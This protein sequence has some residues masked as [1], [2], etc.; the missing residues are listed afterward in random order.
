MKGMT[1]GD[2]YIF[3]MKH[4]DKPTIREMKTMKKWAFLLTVLSLL[5]ITAACARKGGENDAEPK[6]PPEENAEPAFPDGDSVDEI[7]MID[8]DPEELFSIVWST[9]FSPYLDVPLKEFG[10]PSESKI[11]K[12]LNERF[13]VILDS[14]PANSPDY[15]WQTGD[16]K[17]ELF[18]EGRLPDF[19]NTMFSSQEEVDTLMER[20][21]FRRIPWDMV[22]RYAPRYYAMINLDPDMLE[23]YQTDEFLQYMLPA[24][25][26]NESM[27]EYVSIYRLDWLEELGF[28]PKGDI[29]KIFANDQG[30]PVYFTADAFSMDEF[31]LIQEA[32]AGMH[33]EHPN[34]WGMVLGGFARLDR[35][36]RTPLA[37]MFGVTVNTVHENGSAVAWFASERYRKLLE[38]MFRLI[39]KGGIATGMQ[40]WSDISKGV[41][42]DGGHGWFN[43][44][45]QYVFHPWSSPIIKNK[46]LPST[47]K[48][49]IT[50]P[51]IASSGI[52]G[53]TGQPAAKMREIQDTRYW[54][55]GAHVSD[56]K[57]ARILRIWDA[58]S[59]EPDLYVLTNFGIEGEDFNWAGKPFDSPALKTDKKD[60]Y[61]ELFASEVLDGNAGKYIY[62]FGSEVLYNFAVSERGQSMVLVPYKNEFTG[63]FDDERA[64]V[65]ALYPFEDLRA[66]HDRFYDALIRGTK[67]IHRSWDEYMD[68]LFAAGLAEWHKFFELLPV[69]EGYDYR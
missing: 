1:A 56:A 33:L 7:A 46:T 41:F 26:I 19:I 2:G 17:V 28:K 29:T 64:A 18:E 36:Q 52:Q 23:R 68:E 45:I 43:E 35:L 27:L 15:F 62:S 54:C 20:G 69:N 21:A 61:L 24:I 49:L 5:I 32:F 31:I 53:V 47:A 48:Y 58:V 22:E 4:F 39:D 50:P 55:I 51:E 57:L 44:N 12:I 40:E 8:D 14:V 6:A 42:N 65:E 60:E 10:P 66:V 59:F 30:V 16:F 63:E 3:S 37:G 25:K 9:T 34:R 11:A 13:N 38:F 67:D